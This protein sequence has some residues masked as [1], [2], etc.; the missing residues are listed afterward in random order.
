MARPV[1]DPASD[2]IRFDN[3]LNK[4]VSHS[5]GSQ[6]ARKRPPDKQDGSKTKFVLINAGSPAFPT[7]RE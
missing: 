2:V 5:P 6:N 4:A 3:R 1:L 7:L